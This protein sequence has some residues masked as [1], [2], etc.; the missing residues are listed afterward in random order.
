M[1][2]GDLSWIY[3]LNMVIFH[4]YD[5]CLPEAYSFFL[6][7]SWNHPLQAWRHQEELLSEEQVI[8][9][10]VGEGELCRSEL[11]F[12]VVFQGI[13]PGN[14]SFVRLLGISGYE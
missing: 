2:N 3:P 12:D 10:T 9:T 4:I 13:Q 1:E 6:R 11:L 5:V 7:F 14:C 8:E